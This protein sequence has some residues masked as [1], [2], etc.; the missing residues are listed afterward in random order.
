MHMPTFTCKVSPNAWDAYFYRDTY[1]QAESQCLHEMPSLYVGMPILIVRMGKINVYCLHGVPI[2][3][4]GCPYSLWKW[5]PGCLY[6]RKYRHRDAYFYVKIVIWDAYIWGCLYSLDTG[7]QRILRGTGLG[8]S[9]CCYA[10]AQASWMVY[11]FSVEHG[12]WD[13]T[14]SS[15]KNFTLQQ[16]KKIDLIQGVWLKVSNRYLCFFYFY[17][18]PFLIVRI[19]QISNMKVIGLMVYIFK[20]RQTLYYLAKY[21][22]L[23]WVLKSCHSP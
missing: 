1:P 21:W 8:I 23:W 4:A 7:H 20:N 12:F 9:G 5:A 2:F 3:T 16:L 14:R 18:L 11:R 13:L 17:L 22:V 19:A 6:S 10:T 15:I